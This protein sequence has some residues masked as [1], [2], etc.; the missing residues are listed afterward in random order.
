MINEEPYWMTVIDNDNKAS[1]KGS[2]I[3]NH[4]GNTEETIEA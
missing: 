3:W 4:K 2:I 1:N